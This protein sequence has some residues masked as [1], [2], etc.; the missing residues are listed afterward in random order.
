M[1]QAEITGGFQFLKWGLVSFGVVTG[2]D[3]SVNPQ[4][5]T[6]LGIGGQVARAGGLLEFG[7]TATFLVTSTNESLV[8][9]GLRA[10]YPMGALSELE[11]LSGG[12]DEWSLDY[13]TA[14]IMEG[15]LSLTDGGALEAQLRWGAMD[16]AEGAGGTHIAES[17][18]TVEDYE[19]VAQ[20]GGLEYSVLD[21][22]IKWNNNVSFRSNR[23]TVAAGAFRKPR[24]YLVGPE[25]LEL[26][27]VTG[28]PIPETVLGLTDDRQPTNLGMTLTGNN[29]VDTPV[30]TLSN[31]MGANSNMGLVGPNDQATWNYA[32]QGSSVAGSLDFAWAGGS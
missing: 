32:F 4:P 21:F 1:A 12:A 25:E 13:V 23:N 18:L 24:Y 20:F 5:R 30:L 3:L 28:I 15:Q 31:L 2:G 8:A 22:S 10:S 14:L 9:A 7:G 27:L 6:I 29:G 26:E 17:N 11:N 16:A 19:W